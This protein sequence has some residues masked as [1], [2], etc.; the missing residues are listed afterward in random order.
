MSDSSDIHE[1]VKRDTVISRFQCH[2]K[3]TYQLGRKPCAVS[4]MVVEGYGVPCFNAV[5]LCRR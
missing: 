3:Q 5:W 2:K 1:P 4:I